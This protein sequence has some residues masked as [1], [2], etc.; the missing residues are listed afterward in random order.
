MCPKQSNRDLLFDDIDKIAHEPARLMILLH[1]FIVEKADFIYLMKQTGL[2]KGNLSSHL[3][4]LEEAGY[5]NIK[6]EFS[7]KIPHTFLSL[8]DKGRAAFT[9]YRETILKLLK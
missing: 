8:T 3:S 4:K 5:I 1:L 9:A 2:S 7:E 6:K